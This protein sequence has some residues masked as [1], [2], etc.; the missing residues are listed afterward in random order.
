MPYRANCSLIK[1]AFVHARA[2]EYHPLLG[3]LLVHRFA[4]VH[5]FPLVA[6]H[7]HRRSCR[8][9]HVGQQLV[10]LGIQRLRLPD[11]H[12]LTIGPHRKTRRRIPYLRHAGRRPVQ[13][14]L[15]ERPVFFGQQVIFQKLRQRVDKKRFLTH[16][17][18][19]WCCCGRNRLFYLGDLIV[20][21]HVF[22]IYGYSR[23]PSGSLSR[24]GIFSLRRC[25]PSPV[26]QKKQDAPRQTPRGKTPFSPSSLR[27]DFPI[28]S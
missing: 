14:R 1:V 24:G 26:F 16:Q 12:R 5:V 21:F 10:D 2:L 27:S 17:Q 7:Q 22:R 4:P 9:G 13:D 3:D 23:Q 11:D 6:K 8:R 18:V 25:L 28:F 19:Q 15:V 20:L